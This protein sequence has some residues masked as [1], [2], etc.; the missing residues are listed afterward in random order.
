GF[1][2]YTT[3]DTVDL[4]TGTG[5]S[6]DIFGAYTGQGFAYDTDTGNLYF[7]ADG[8]GTGSEAMLITT[9]VGRPALTVDD[10]NVYTG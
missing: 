5:T 2:S 10:I 7:D 9:L 6:D 3:L 4:F 1:G 8:S